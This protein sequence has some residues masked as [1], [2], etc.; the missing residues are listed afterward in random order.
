MWHIAKRELYDN[1]NSLR[2][3]LAIVLLIGLMLTNA[4]VH[5]HEHPKRIQVYSDGVT[6][7]QNHLTAS[8]DESLY[9]L[10]QKGPGDLYKKP[11]ALRFCA[12]GSETDLPGQAIGGLLRWS[13]DRLESS[14]ILAYPPV[15]T[16]LGN[17]RPDVTLVDWSFIIG[18]VLSLI[19]LLFTFDSISGERE[20]G[21]LRLILANA[22]PRHTVL[23]GKFLGALISLN[24]PFTLAILMNLLVI[25][26]SSDVHLNAE[27]WGRLSIIFF[28][29]LLYTCLFLALGLL[30]SARVQRSAVSL[31]ILLLVW[32]SLVVFMPGTLAAIAGDAASPKATHGFYERSW[33]L[34]N[35]LRDQYRSRWRQARGDSRKKIEV[36]GAYVSKDAEQQAHLH[37]ERLKQ[38]ISQVN[39][40]RAITRM[41]PV[42]IVQHL[43]E[44]FAGT[45]FERHLQFLENVKVYAREYREF[46]LDTDKAD[47]ESLHI[48]GVRAGMSQKP[49]S[50]EAVPKFE[51][52]LNFSKDF[53]TA[54]ID[55]LLLTLF[56]VVLLSGAYLAFVRVEV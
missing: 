8:A 36:D 12:E 53:N 29:A 26:T 18:Y 51:D 30:V 21:T 23:I 2:F 46:V 54:A 10:A 32:V 31:V 45:G 38:Q 1:L 28:I 41:S 40:A 20:R 48:I 39:R 15:D 6:E 5:L 34:H 47:P 33:Q 9:R 50:P 13:T 43:F 19:A 52:T 3:A 14:W 25:S 17:L 35:E 16:S 24:I 4:V 22:I 56:F 27:A 49:V 42:T 44:S 11:S 7:Y 55:L 37:E